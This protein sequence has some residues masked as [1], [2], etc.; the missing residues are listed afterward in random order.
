MVIGFL[1]W[2][3]RDVTAGSGAE[4]VEHE[5][6]Y[7]YPNHEKDLDQEKCSRPPSGNHRWMIYRQTGERTLTFS[8]FPEMD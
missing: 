6:G 1:P 7:S 8:Q 3:L 2:I 5:Q 4:D